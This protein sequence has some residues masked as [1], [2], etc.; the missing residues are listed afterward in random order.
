MKNIRFLGIIVL[1][2]VMV[3]FASCATAANM[4]GGYP[5]SDPQGFLTSAGSAVEAVGG[6]EIASYSI[7]LGLFT[8]GYAE[9]VAAVRAAEAEGATISTV[10][11]F[12]LFL[13]KTTAYAN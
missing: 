5:H 2:A 13:T 12:L 3:S 9:Y 1:A 4:G 11:T 6:T 10:S 7:I 8:S